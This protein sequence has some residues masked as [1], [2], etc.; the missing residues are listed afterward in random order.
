M[1][2]LIKEPLI[3][4]FL[5]GA[6]LFVLYSQVNKSDTEQDIVVDNADVEH[7][8]ELWRMQW[9]RPPTS[10]ELQGLIDK[11]VNQEVLYREALRMNLDHNDE[12]VKRRLAQKMEFL[13]QDLSGL[14]APASE[15]NL[16][17]YF[18][19]HKKDFATPYRYNL[20]QI[21]FTADN[22]VNPYDKAKAVLKEYNSL[23][24]QG[25][26]EKGDPF[27][28]DYALQ[29]TDAFY[30]NREFGEQFSQQLETLPTGEWAG[31]IVSGYGVHLVFIESRT[32]PSIPN[33]ADVK[34]K[35]QRDYEYQM[36]QESQAAILKAL[37]DNYK[38]RITA[39]NLEKATIDE[40]AQ[41]QQP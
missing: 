36:E 12:I 34:D 4:F 8:A 33:F 18:E 30:L 13:G 37:R 6:L 32:P 17:A 22:H 9:Q 11:Y 14:V 3:H 23:D 27:L 20:Y 38:V 41:N 40:L 39:D 5:L 15:D 7:M 2:Q 10:E 28:L 25:M 35:V 24:T 1:K 19:E 16:K 21:L 31:P 26:R 29:D